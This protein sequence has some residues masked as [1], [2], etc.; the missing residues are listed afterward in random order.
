MTLCLILVF[1]FCGFRRVG[2]AGLSHDLGDGYGFYTNF[3]VIS[4]IFV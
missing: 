4:G 1:M 3:P 2:V